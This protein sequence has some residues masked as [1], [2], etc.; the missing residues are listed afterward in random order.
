MNRNIPVDAT[1][2]DQMIRAV[3]DIVPVTDFDD[4]KQKKTKDGVPKY[5]VQLLV[6][7]GARKPE[8]MEVNFASIQVPEFDPAKR[9][10]FVGLTVSA[11]ENTNEY[12][13]S[14][15][16]SWSCDEVRFR[17]AP[18]NGVKTPADAESE[19]VAA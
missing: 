13:T 6:A 14:S 4:G 17:S 15:G 9:P 12:G 5:R 2:F 11:W 10:V 18:H 8:V 16:V 19:P 1:V 7:T 3:I